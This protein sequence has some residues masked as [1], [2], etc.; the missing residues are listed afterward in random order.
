MS[1]E[2]KKAKNNRYFLVLLMCGQMLCFSHQIKFHHF[3]GIFS[4]AFLEHVLTKSHFKL[5]L[6]YRIKG[7]VQPK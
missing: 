7:M 5:L 1:G 6:T 2:Q 3:K 4:Q